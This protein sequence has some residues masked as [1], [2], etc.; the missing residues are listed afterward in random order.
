MLIETLRLAV[1]NLR[2]SPRRTFLTSAA[3]ANA[4]VAALL[5]YGFTRHTYWGLA[6][7]FARAG[8]GHV[9]V[10]EGPWFDAAVPEAHRETRATLDEVRAALA[11]DPELAPLLAA[12][13]VRRTVSGML[14]AGPRTAVFAGVG[15]DPAAEATLA[16]LAAPTSGRRLDGMDAR[17]LVL[18][19][20]LA[21][22]LD[23]A[24]GG[25]VTALTTT[26]GGLTNAMDLTVA[27]VASSGMDEL[28]RTFASM[29]LGTALALV[30][31]AEADVLVIALQD[32]RDT[33]K[34]LAATR[35]VLTRW[36]TLR[37]EP[38][39]ARADYYIAVRALYDRIFGV[40]QGLMALVSIL[41]LSHG[42]AA[43]VAERRHEIA[44]LRVAGLTRREVAGLFVVEGALL[45]GLAAVAGS[46]MA[47][48]VAAITER[49]GGIPMPPPPGF[50]IGYAAM[51]AI[52]A[53]GFAI[54]LPITILTAM[55]GSA[56][57]AWRATRGALSRGL[58]G[59]AVLLGL[60]IPFAAHAQDG[61]T[62]LA[63]ADAAATLAGRCVVELD[64]T[65][66]TTA[67]HWRAALQGGDALVV[68]TSLAEGRRQA[69]LRRGA[70]TWFQTEAM[71]N[72][73]KV[74]ASQRLAGS[75]SPG[76]LLAPRLVET[77]AP[78]GPVR[79]E[80]T[81]LVVPVTGR[82]GA[83]WPRADLVLSAGHLARATFYAPSGQVARTAAWTWEG[84]SLRALL[85]E[86]PARKTQARVALGAP[87]CGPAAAAVEPGGLLAAARQ[88]LAE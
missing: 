53:T 48:V 27:G 3:L 21:A 37:A 44:L 11:A 39:D 16:P 78:A 41:S 85:V 9:Q 14:T 68:S 29:P 75:L 28:D 33:A 32:T 8:N 36:P 4:V 43:V 73:M 86:D 18:G 13:A 5:F 25:T 62:L 67:S 19:A 31:G 42:V 30:D 81:S 12:T 26:D 17:E 83:A 51:F 54:V 60:A 58:V 2:Q 23:V 57:P 40:F 63:Q 65:E 69:V 66:G 77:W 45:G 46:G 34:A 56:I 1:A 72:P 88:L 35:R 70:D 6:E 87:R 50:T 49:L 82:A 55:V 10:A 80:G 47:L 76:D 59:L 71:A 15:T 7:T 84:S 74:G 64:I 24:P 38:W 22:R 61:A 79:A 20:T 52:D